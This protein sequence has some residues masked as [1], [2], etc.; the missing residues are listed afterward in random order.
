MRSFLSRWPR[1]GA[2]V[3]GGRDSDP[4]P[5]ERIAGSRASWRGRLLAAL[6]GAAVVTGAQA[7]LLTETYSSGPL[8]AEIPDDSPVLTSFLMATGGS[9]IVALTRVRL[10]L[11]LAG[12]TQGGGYAGDMFASL[13]RSPPSGS[14]SVDDPMAVLLNRVEGSYDGWALTFEDGSGV[15]IFGVGGTEGILNGVFEPD[16]RRTRGDAERPSLLE[17]FEGLGGAADW[18]LNLGDLAE[19]GTMRLTGWSLELT[20][21]GVGGGAEVP[22]PGAWFG[23]GAAVAML[24]TGMRRRR[25]RIRSVGTGPWTRL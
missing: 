16:G 9:E 17:V 12:S 15:D 18:R 2:R 1:S 7:A 19:Y 21:E 5:W 23:V 13:I 6:A 14:M 10:T 11:E 25:I 20:G 22:E 8:D 3:F 4:A 24:G